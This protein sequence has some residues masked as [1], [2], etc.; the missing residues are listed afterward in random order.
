M[1]DRAR[2]RGINV[3]KAVAEALPFSDNEF[4][5]A[6]MVTTVCILDDIEMAFLAAFRVLNPGGAFVIGLVDRDS[7][8][9]KA[10]EQRKSESL[11]YKNG[12]RRGFLCGDQGRKVKGAAS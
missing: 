4:D 5:S 8:L 7:P 9:G 6:L 3:V 10:Y 12:I 1:G 2:Q 11:F